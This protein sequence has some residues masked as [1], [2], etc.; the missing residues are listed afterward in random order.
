MGLE[1][2]LVYR[3]I[4]GDTSFIHNG[5]FTIAVAGQITVDD[6]NGI[7][8]SLFGDFT[9]TG[10]FDVPDQNVTASSVAGINVGDTVDPRIRYTITGSDGSGGT[11]F[12]LATNEDSN[13]NALLA[14]DVPLTPGVTYRF[15]ALDV[16]AGVPYSDLVPCFVKGT[17]ITTEFGDTLVEH[18]TVGDKV[19]TADNGLQEIK[20]IGA[21]ALDS[22]DLFANP[23]LR[24]VRI[25]AG[26]LG[27]DTPNCDLHVSPQHRVLIASR[28]ADRMFET[29]EVLVPAV[30]LVG[31]PG[32]DV[33]TDFG[34]VEYFHILFD[35]HQ[36]IFSD[37]AATESLYT[38]P[39]A[40]RSINPDAR[41]EVLALFPQIETKDYS[42]ALARPVPDTGHLMRR[43][44]A[45]HGANGQPLQ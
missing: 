2:I 22:I 31:L 7:S 30:R 10:G 26:A 11:V 19:L 32:I 12:V 35:A 6:S 36:I 45:R 18:L 33:A 34:P 20:W 42:P 8:D 21:R 14:S 13:F 16:D 17:M 43:L 5:N 37:G 38:G 4:T 29:D 23:K 25:K 24:P 27:P 44:I 9:H 3:I 40:L 41:A 15:G 39:E 1:N 28:I